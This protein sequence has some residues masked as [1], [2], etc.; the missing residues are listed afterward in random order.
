MALP[1]KPTRKVRLRRRLL[2]V[3]L[4]GIAPLALIAGLG[5]AAIIHEQKSIAEQ[6]SLEATRLAATAIE[7]E[8]NRSL[9]LLKTL[10]Q[11]PF[12]D[13]GDLDN[14]QELIRRVVPLVPG[15]KLSFSPHRTV[16][17]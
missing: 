6:R 8:I 1:S 10:S 9:D 3:S 2:T 5:L 7:V 16:K 17:S 12:L 11:S 13:D 4:A 15:W 14:Y